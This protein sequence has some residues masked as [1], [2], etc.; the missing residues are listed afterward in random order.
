LGKDGSFEVLVTNLIDRNLYPVDKLKE[1]YHLRWGVEECYK[2]IK[3]V[4]Q[5]EY[6]SGRTV[7]SIEQDFEAR[8]VLLNIMAMIETQ[9][10]QPLLEQ[11]HPPLKYKLQINKTQTM[12]KL[13][14]FFYNIFYG[15]NIQE[16]INKMLDLAKECYDII[17]PN[18]NFKR[19]QIF[20][21]R[22]K[23]LA[24]KAS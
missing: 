23:P 9:S 6:F 14:D 20:R 15:K 7:H 5:M 1:L 4:S 11:K 21:Q 12:A 24:Y 13:R 16:A 2:R 10:L 18:R 17:R 22:R 3:H 19:P 8:I